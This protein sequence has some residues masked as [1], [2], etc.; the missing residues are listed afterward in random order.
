MSPMSRTDHQQEKSSLEMNHS[1]PKTKPT[2]FPPSPQSGQCE[3]QEVDW[4]GSHLFTRRNR[5]P[6]Q[7]LPTAMWVYQRV[8]GNDIQM[9]TLVQMGYDG[10]ND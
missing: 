9:L 6:L 3:R 8:G 4:P 2:Q 7:T 10:L 5:A 1:C